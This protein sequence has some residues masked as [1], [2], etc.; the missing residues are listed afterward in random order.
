MMLLPASTKVHLA[1]GHTDMRKGIDGLAT[2][3]PLAQ[4]AASGLVQALARGSACADPA[5]QHAGRCH[6]LCAGALGKPHPVPRRWPHRARYQSG[7]AGDPSGRAR[8]QE[9]PVRRLRWRRSPLGYN[10]LAHRNRQA[11]QRRTLRL[12]QR[13]PHPHG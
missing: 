9:P 1:L 7:R 11:Q 4:R 10:L 13:C 6:P 5:Q 12:A 2:M 3:A 8:A